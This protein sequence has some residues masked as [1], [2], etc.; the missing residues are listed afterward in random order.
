[1][2]TL[3]KKVN[4]K[5]KKKHKKTVTRGH[6]SSVP[7]NP[8]IHEADSCLNL[9]HGPSEVRFTRKI[10]VRILSVWNEQLVTKRS[11]V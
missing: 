5:K 4:V 2:I 10:K 9:T 6:E 3:D 11:I 7:G 1:M 8:P